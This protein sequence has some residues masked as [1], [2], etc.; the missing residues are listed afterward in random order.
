MLA[1]DIVS[2]IVHVLTAITLVGGSIFTLFVLMPSAK[3]L[4]DDA[5]HQLAAAITGRWKRFVHLGIAL[6]LITGFYNY[7]QAIPLHKGDGPYHALVGTKMI[8]AFGIFFLASALVGKSEKLAGIRAN[9]G[10]WLKVL[11]LLAVVVVSLSGYVKVRG[12]PELPADEVAAADVA[13]LQ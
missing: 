5:H 4:A 7:M 9:R 12:V 13:P 11:V 10:K 1:I 3:E 8:L 6:F 2:R